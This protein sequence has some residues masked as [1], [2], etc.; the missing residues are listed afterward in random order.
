MG[1]LADPETADP[2]A[3]A[4]VFLQQVPIEDVRQ[5]L[6]ELG[7]GDWEAIGV[8]SIAPGAVAA[9]LEGP[10]PAL[11]VQLQVDAEGLIA[12]LL[13]Q[14]AELTDP[15]VDLAGLVERVKAAAPIAGFLRADVARGR[16][17]LTGRRAGIERA[18]ADRV[19][20]QALRPRGRGR[21]DR[22]R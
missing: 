16:V 14:P 5:I 1:W 3:F 22:L 13:F 15:P 8:E 7:A 17:V 4:D 20:V 6:S 21:H 10:G 19:G 11:V 2:A 12:G 9:R 18:A